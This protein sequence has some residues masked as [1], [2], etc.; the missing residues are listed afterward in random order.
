MRREMGRVA[1]LTVIAVGCGPAIPA[2]RLPVLVPPEPT[3]AET[4][5][6]ERTA[7]LRATLLRSSIELDAGPTIDTCRPGEW[8]N[9]M[10]CDVAT[11]MD[12]VDPDLLDRVAIV[13]ASYPAPLLE[14]AELEHL[15]LCRRIRYEGKE[16]GPVGLAQLREHRL[17]ISVE[18]Y[19]TEQHSSTAIEQI[20]HHELFHLFDH[21]NLGEAHLDPAWSELTPPGFEYRDP[22]GSGPRPAGFVNAYATTDAMEDRASTFEY[23]MAH[24][25]TCQIAA[26]DPIVD[27]KLTVVRERIT[28][29]APKFL[30]RRAPCTGWVAP[31]AGTPTYRLPGR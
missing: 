20:V 16:D 4:T 9:C 17:M 15:A 8:K 12:G 6:A 28:A 13:I 22:A 1:W 5:F 18:G 2:H 7:M 24:D 11:G 21:A 19:M 3:V 26:I 27:A 31:A 29:V 23:L 10:R 25:E 14:A 30:D